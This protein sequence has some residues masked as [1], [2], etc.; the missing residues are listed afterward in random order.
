MTTIT[1]NNLKPLLDSTS[2]FVD[3]IKKN[4]ETY[5]QQRVLME[6]EYSLLQEK[7]EKLKEKYTLEVAEWKKLYEGELKRAA[8]TIGGKFTKFV[9]LTE[10][11]RNNS[12]GYLPH[13]VLTNT[14]VPTVPPIT[15]TVNPVENSTLFDRELKL[16]PGNRIQTKK[17]REKQPLVVL[18]DG[19]GTT[20]N[21]VY[22]IKTKIT[23]E[24][25][26]VVS[27]PDDISPETLPVT[28]DTPEPATPQPAVVTATND[29][30]RRNLQQLID[31][32][33]DPVQKKNLQRIMESIPT[34]N[35]SN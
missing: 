23:T 8:K 11:E 9:P 26:Y 13:P 4:E 33:T 27:S 32:E 5:Q 19:A 1:F 16:P 12:I 20:K 18:N 10:E 7:N 22:D 30:R 2:N 24:N 29:T 34:N 35:P 31:T 15:D 14:A 25:G 6:K 21:S 3:I 17:V 28:V